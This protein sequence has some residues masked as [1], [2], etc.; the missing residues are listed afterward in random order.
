MATLQVRLFGTLQVAPAGS[1]GELQLTGRLRDLFAYLVTHRDRPQ[2]RDVLAGLF[3]GDQPEERAR[4]CLSTAL[5]RLRRTLGK[6]A[7]CDRGLDTSSRTSVVFV[8]PPGCRIDVAE[9]ET[10]LRPLVE[11]APAALSPSQVAQAEAAL[12]LYRGPLLDGV[13]HDWALRERERICSLNLEAHALLMRHHTGRR[14]FARSVAHGQQI[15][16]HDP[17]REEIHRELVRLYL[18]TGQR[19]LALRQYECCRETLRR[20]LDVSPMKETEVL[21][22]QIFQQGPPADVATPRPESSDALLSLRAAM[23]DFDAAYRRLEGVMRQIDPSL[24]PL[25]CPPR[26]R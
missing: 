15:L 24:S 4:G 19:A 1:Q 3:W 25:Q 13:Y 10:T 7:G 12:T 5:W 21:A 11:L 18:L 9:F 16:A 23:S 26:D 14:E 17:V 6:T 22:R 8:A 20:E 2:P